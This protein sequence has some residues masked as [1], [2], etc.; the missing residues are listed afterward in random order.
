MQQE[1][2]KMAFRFV[3]MFIVFVIL[4]YMIQ[5]QWLLVQGLIFAVIYIVL[6]YVLK[7]AFTAFQ[8]KVNEAKGDET[9]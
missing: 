2:M 8:R 9:K 1:M 3:I 5:G 6:Y 7:R 4:L